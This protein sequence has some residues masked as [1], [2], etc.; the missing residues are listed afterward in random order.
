MRQKKNT[1]TIKSLIETNTVI[2]EDK[3][4]DRRNDNVKIKEE[5]YALRLTLDLSRST[6]D[7]NDERER[8]R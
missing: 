1:N 6:L 4:N 3:R 5:E 7:V 2:R 8:Q